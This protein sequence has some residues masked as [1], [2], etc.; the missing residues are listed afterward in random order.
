MDDL[1]QLLAEAFAAEL[2][3]HLAAIRAGLTLAA[4]DGLPDLRDIFRRA[5][6]LKGA[7]RAVDR[8]DVETIAHTLESLLA[9]VEQGAR[10]L[11]GAPSTRCASCSTR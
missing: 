3:E 5:H 2:S 10:P 1:Q 6:S 8:E 11:R 7:A 9:D 4:A